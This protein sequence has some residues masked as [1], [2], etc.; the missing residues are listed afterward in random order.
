M[1][2]KNF[3]LDLDQTL[4][5]AEPTEEYD[6]SKNKLKAKQFTFHDMDGFY[7]VFERP[8]LQ[9]FLAFL[10][11]NFNV[12]IWTAASKD[13]ALFV[14]DKIILAGNSNR[15]LDYIFF[16]YHCDLSE[17]EKDS[18]KNLKLL[19][20]IFKLPGYNMDNTI[21]LDDYDEVWKS[22]K[23]NCIYAK[24][25][26]FSSKSSESDKFLLNLIP[27]LRKLLEN[28]KVQPSVKKITHNYHASLRF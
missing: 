5:S 1:N 22:Q 15:K 3:I 24:Q 13:Y 11:D 18:T 9:K 19:T 26:Q 23:G 14:I 7:V 8:H 4:I 27:H 12:S 10:F 2:K 20:D 16:S 28:D 6:F 21:I 25:F 17:R